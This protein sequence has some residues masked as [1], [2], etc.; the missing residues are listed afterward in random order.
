[1]RRTDREIKPTDLFPSAFTGGLNRYL[2]ISMASY[3]YDGPAPD[4]AVVKVEREQ[5]YK[6]KVWIDD[7]VD[8]TNDVIWVRCLGD[9]VLQDHPWLLLRFTNHAHRSKFLNDFK[10][11]LC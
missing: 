10:E 9:Q 7:L 4:E 3:D 6:I 11:Y 8:K 2:P 5:H 1:M